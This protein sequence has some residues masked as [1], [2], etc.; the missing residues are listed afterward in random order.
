MA[1]WRFKV[2]YDGDCPICS[3][4]VR[5][6][7]RLNKKGYLAF[8]DVADPNFDPAKYGKTYGELM[9]AIHGV[10][11]DGTVIQG[12]EVFRQTYGLIGL[13]W[14]MTPTKWPLLRHLFDFLYSVFAR[15]RVKLGSVL[16]RKCSQGCPVH[17]GN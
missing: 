15:Y 2:L 8:E 5:W 3:T 16:G 11:P 13:G 10:F 1:E 7:K 9:S 4:E 6:L 12:V 17:F 14:L